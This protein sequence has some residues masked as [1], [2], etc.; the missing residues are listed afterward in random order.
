[1]VSSSW[2][3]LRMCKRMQGLAPNL[4]LTVGEYGDKTWDAVWDSK[5][6][7]SA[8]WLDCRNENTLFLIAVCQKRYTG[9][10]IAIS[11]FDQAE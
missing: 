2:L 1:M 5:V 4:T 11:S 7:I 8:R 9:L 10:G 6:S 3:L